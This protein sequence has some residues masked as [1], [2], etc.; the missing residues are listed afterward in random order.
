MT[1]LLIADEPTTALDVTVQAEIL[2][3]IRDLRDRLGSAVL[4]IT[5]DMGVV[6]DLADH[7]VV[8]QQGEVVE[9]GPTREIFRNPQHEYTRPSWRPCRTWGRPVARTTDVES[10]KRPWQG[11]AAVH[12][13]R[14]P[15]TDDRRGDHD[16]EAVLN[17]RTSSSSTRA[18]DGSRR[19]EPSTT[20]ISS[21]AEGEVVGLV[22]E[23]GSGKSTLGRAAIGLLPITEGHP[24]SSA[25][26]CRSRLACADRQVHKN[27]GIV[28]QDPRR[29]STRG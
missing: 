13:S 3:L 10:T 18:G 20:S 5:H 25:S 17:S 7:I 12:M 4:L 24:T 26:T 22:G 6:A 23:S 9:A 1:R 14:P 21:F 27:A 16:T 29:R 19:S 8:M 15:S 11:G 2:D 28:F